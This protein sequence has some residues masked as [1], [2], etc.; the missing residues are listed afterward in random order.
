MLKTDQP[1]LSKWWQT[2]SAQA[3]IQRAKEQKKQQII[4][5]REAFAHRKAE[6]QRASMEWKEVK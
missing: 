6:L 3:A 2:Q 5:M 1:L 4:K